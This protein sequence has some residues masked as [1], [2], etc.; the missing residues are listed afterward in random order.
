DAAAAIADRKDHAITEI[1]V[2][3][4]AAFRLA[5]QPALEQQRLGH[6]VAHHRAFQLVAPIRRKAE[7]ETSDRRVVETALLEIGARGTAFG[8]VQHRLKESAS[9]VD[10]G[11]QRRL[12]LGTLALLACLLR[13]FESGTA[14]ELLD[15]FGKRQILGLHGEADDVAVRAAAE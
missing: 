12:A 6:G 1:V 4:A 11:L 10:R 13:H 2:A 7:A 3:V 9:G 5:Q 8:T 14:R 15:G